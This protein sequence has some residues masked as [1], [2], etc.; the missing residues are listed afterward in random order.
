MSTTGDPPELSIVV[1]SWN[2]ADLLGA[3]LASLEACR[4][5]LPLE[6]V[7]V[8]NA[9]ADGS[10]DMV[11]ARFP[12]CTLVR[13]PRNEGYAIGNNVGAARARGE[14]LLLLNSDTEVPRGV[15]PVLVGFL[16]DHPA[17]GACAPRLDHPDGT[18][19]RSCKRFPS[20]LVAVFYDT[21]FGRWFERNRTI[22]RYLMDDFDHVSSR[23]VEQPPG[24]ALVIRRALFER[25]GG[26]DP[27]LWLFFNDVDLCRRMHALGAKVRYLAEVRVL[28]HEGRSTA[29]FPEFGA[30]WHKNRCAYYRKAFGGIGALVARVMTA[31][32]GAE[33]VRRLRSSG[34]PPEARRRVWQAVREVWTA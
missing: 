11:A 19:Q 23:D 2:T 33:E 12:W 1:L 5:E 18:V 16:R 31:W 22:P 13:N 27:E 25:L 8:D 28:H 7:V 4:D 24:A 10:A 17:Y 15:L 20:L 9:S 3:C 30:M 34:A 26:L 14:L 29:Q 32:R 21:W 6:V